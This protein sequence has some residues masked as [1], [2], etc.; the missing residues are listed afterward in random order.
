MKYG[1]ECCC[2]LDYQLL[3]GL[4]ESYRPMVMALENSGMV[5]TGDIVKT[6]LLQEIPPSMKADP[7]FVSKAPFRGKTNNPTNQAPKGPKCR[8]CRKF[9]HIA[10]DC[11]AKG[12]QKNFKPKQGE[13]FCTVLSAVNEED[14]NDWFFNSGS[15]RHLSRN[16]D[17]LSNTQRADGNIYAANKGVMKI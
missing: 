14:R 15:C 17:L 2:W 7:A 5:I 4:P 13:A 8:C 11:P 9:G 10:R 6:K 1:S 16:K 12:S 3:A